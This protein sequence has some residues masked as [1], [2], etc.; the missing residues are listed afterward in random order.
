VDQAW[1]PSKV[2]QSKALRN[3]VIFK[4]LHI[5]VS[6]GIAYKNNILSHYHISPIMNMVN[7]IKKLILFIHH[8]KL[9][10]K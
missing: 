10:A 7:I 2:L 4:E 3:A 9:A 1:M 5:M 6:L 8:Y